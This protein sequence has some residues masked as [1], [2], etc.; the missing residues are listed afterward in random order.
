MHV[1]P[2]TK[3]GL[4]IDNGASMDGTC[5]AHLG[6]PRPP[7]RFRWTDRTIS[8]DRPG[9]TRS[10][11]P[12]SSVDRT[13]H[14]GEPTAALRLTDIADSVD[15]VCPPSGDPLISAKGRVK[16]SVVVAECPRRTPLCGGLESC[17]V[18]QANPSVWSKSPHA[19]CIISITC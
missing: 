7:W 6:S 14:L 4:S 1:H 9:P 11:D 18:E 15:R 10:T 2:L 5:L 16:T 19:R 3:P 13:C 12:A 17:G 8:V